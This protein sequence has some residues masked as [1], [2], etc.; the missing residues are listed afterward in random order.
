[1]AGFMCGSGYGFAYKIVRQSDSEALRGDWEWLG[2]DFRKVM[3]KV[4]SGL[5]RERGQQGELNFSEPA[6][7]CN[8]ITRRIR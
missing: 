7:R 3:G 5:D 2:G 8:G 6:R 4:Q 1:M